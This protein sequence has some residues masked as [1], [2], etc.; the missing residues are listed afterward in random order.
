[1]K[2]RKVL[3]LFIVGLLFA[4]AAGYAQG[5][6]PPEQTPTGRFGNPTG[7]ARQYQSYISGVI[8]KVGKDE[9]VLEKTRFGVDTS[10]KLNVKTKYVQNEKPGKL[11]DLKAGDLVF[12]DVK[13]DKK[14]GEMSAKKVVSGITPIS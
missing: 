12:V 6:K 5:T 10:I 9:I 8:K 2:L 7:I 4:T 3:L 13:K 14:T 11:D 1:M